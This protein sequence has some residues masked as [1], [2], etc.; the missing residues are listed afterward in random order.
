[1]KSTFERELENKEFF[2]AKSKYNIPQIW[3][4]DVLSAKEKAKKRMLKEIAPLLSES[5]FVD[6]IQ[7]IKE[8]L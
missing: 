7:I 3:I 4:K 1:M 5:Q 6:I 2:T 8:H